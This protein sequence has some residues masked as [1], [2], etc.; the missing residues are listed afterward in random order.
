MLLWDYQASLLQFGVGTVEEQP[1]GLCLQ[2]QWAVNAACF[3]LP[4][5]QLSWHMP[6]ETSAV[7]DCKATCDARRAL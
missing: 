1:Y 2:T 7:T 6:V 5:M 4:Q 3:P